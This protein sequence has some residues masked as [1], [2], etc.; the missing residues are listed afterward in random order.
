[1]KAADV[2]RLFLRQGARVGDA[3]VRAL[4][5]A[6]QRTTPRGGRG[7]RQRVLPWGTHTSFFGQGG[8]SFQAPTFR[9]RVTFLSADHAEV[10]WTGPGRIGGVQPTLLEQ[11]LFTPG[12]DG[13][14]PAL[15][16]ERST[17]NALGEI[18]IYFRCTLNVAFAIARAEPVALG[19]VPPREPAVVHKL[20]LTLRVRR[21][22]LSY[23]EADDRALHASLGF[24]AAS[25]TPAGTVEPLWWSIV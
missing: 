25:R 6:L 13:R 16:V 22:R 5:A 15:T 23:V 8:G 24:Y 11:D 3:Q 12:A 18:A 9:P 1:M 7:V 17:A 2:E 19:T 20:A 14:T 4:D 21:D 10:R